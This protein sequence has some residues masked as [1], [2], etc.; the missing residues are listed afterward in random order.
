MNAVSKGFSFQSS[1]IKNKTSIK[2]RSINSA[3]NT[4]INN[5][6][7]TFQ[8]HDIFPEYIELWY[9][10]GRDKKVKSLYIVNCII[11]SIL[12]KDEVESLKNDFERYLHKYIKPMSVFDIVGPS[13]IGPSSSHTAGANKIGQIARNIIIAKTKTDKSTV[14]SIGVKLLG[15]FRDTGP[16]HY[17]PSALGG[18][19]HGLPPDHPQMLQHGDPVFMNKNGIDFIDFKT[20]FAGYKKGLIEEE[21]KYANENNNNIAEIIVNTSKGAYTITGFSIGG[22]NVE[23]RYIDNRLSIPLTG[24]EE[25]F[26]HDCKIITPAEAKKTTNAAII[27]P[28][29]IVS[30]SAKPNFVMP[31]NSFEELNKY[32]KK[33]N[34]DLID[35]ILDVEKNLQGTSTEETLIKVAEYWRIMKAS[36]KKGIKSHELSLLKLTGKDANKIHKYVKKQPMQ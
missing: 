31:F 2:I 11:D 32:L 19:L 14:K 8:K 7:E 23:V 29:V 21:S 18:G 30:K 28:I 5:V 27:P 34:K 16:G 13:M 35:V 26:Y 15:S 9:I 1:K 22:G 4:V 36:V 24:K 12:D 33:E 10:K 25:F 3:R 6:V 20:S 17:T